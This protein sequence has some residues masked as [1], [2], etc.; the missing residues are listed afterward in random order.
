VDVINYCVFALGFYQ[1]SPGSPSRV[2]IPVT[3]QL[4]VRTRAVVGPALPGPGAGS[5]S[6]SG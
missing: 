3:H 6:V 4:Q 1:L 2:Y 5:R